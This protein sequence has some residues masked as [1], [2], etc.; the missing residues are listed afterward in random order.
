[1]DGSGQQGNAYPG[2]GGQIPTNPMMQQWA[3]YYAAAQAA[4]YA[5]SVGYSQAGTGSTQ[6][7][8]VM[9]MSNSGMAS[10]YGTKPVKKC[11]LHNKHNNGCKK[12]RE[13]KEWVVA[14][15]NVGNIRNGSLTVPSTMF[16]CLYRLFVMRINSKVLGQLINYHGAPYV[17]CAGFLYVRFGLSPRDYWSF[18]QPHLLDDEEFTPGCDKGRIIT[19]GEYVEKLLTEDRYYSLLII[20]RLRSIEEIP[21][22]M[23]VLKSGENDDWADDAEWYGAEQSWYDAPAGSAQ[24]QSWEEGAEGGAWTDAAEAVKDESK[25]TV[26][27]THRKTAGNF[28]DEAYKGMNALDIYNQRRRD[29]AS[30]SATSGKGYCRPVQGYRNALSRP[31]VESGVKGRERVRVKGKGEQYGEGVDYHSSATFRERSPPKH[32]VS[33]ATRVRQQAIVGRYSGVAE[34]AQTMDGINSFGQR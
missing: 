25:T 11:F 20:A 7:A 30:V 2:G 22:G 34:T 3:N 21:L 16:C 27:L 33:E 32:Q 18:L 15:L 24:A 10:S 17:R 1:M 28:D 31:H 23:V 26:D 9:S 14:T 12:C 8:S 19:M 13:Y 29:K 5:A 4:A 6:A